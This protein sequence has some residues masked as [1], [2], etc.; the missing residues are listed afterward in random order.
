VEVKL[1]EHGNPKP[2]FP[3][4]R[5]FPVFQTPPIKGFDIEKYSDELKG[6]E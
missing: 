3:P 1:D 5:P 4:G 6:A 2:R